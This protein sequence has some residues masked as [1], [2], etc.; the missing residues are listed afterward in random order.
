M[1]PERMNDADA[2]KE[3]R[4]CQNWK[5]ELPNYTGGNDGKVPGREATRQVS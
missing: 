5:E 2:L 1:E 4:G 3:A